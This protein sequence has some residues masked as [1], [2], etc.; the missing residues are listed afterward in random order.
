LNVDQAVTKYKALFDRYERAAKDVSNL[1]K[2]IAAE[3]GISCRVSGRAKDVTSFHKKAIIKNYSDPWQMITDKAGVRAVLEKPSDVDELAD[4]IK[5]SQSFEVTSHEDKRQAIKPSELGYSGVHLQVFAPQEIEDEEQISCEIQLRTVAQDAWSIV[6][7][8]L[9]Y[10][11]V[12]E[13]PRDQQRAIYRLVALVEL[14][15][16]EVQRIIDSMPHLPGYENVDLIET[17]EQEYISLVKAP[18]NREFSAF[19]LD[20]INPVF[21]ERERRNYPEK[22]RK[23]VISESDRLTQIYKEFGPHSAMASVPSYSMF[24]QAESLIILERLSCCPMKLMDVWINAGLSAKILDPLA[25]A[26]DIDTYETDYF[27]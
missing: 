22:L 18:S 12:I 7:H 19:I 10:K 27:D 14:F 13:L 26:L 6:S 17:A 15:D 21:S 9:L 23:F 11:P 16:E 24:S 2:E 5:E 1:I 20:K 3:K 25:E 4:A 8:K